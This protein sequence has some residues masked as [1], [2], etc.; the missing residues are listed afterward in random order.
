MSDIT[1]RMIEVCAAMA[2]AYGAGSIIN[3][4]KNR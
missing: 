1:F 4:I 3:R 2:G